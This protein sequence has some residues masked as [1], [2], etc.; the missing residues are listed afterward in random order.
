MRKNP[1]E[2]LMKVVKKYIPVDY[3]VH[4]TRGADGVDGRVVAYVDRYSHIA[5][6]YKVLRTNLYSLSPGKPIKT[7]VIT[8][9]HAWEGKTVTC[10]NTAVTLASDKEKKVL[11][12]DADLRNPSVHS[13]FGIPLDP[14]LAEILEGE[15]SVETFI[16]KPAVGD[17]YIIPAG[18]FAGDPLEVLNPAK[19]EPLIAALK[20]KFDYIVFD[21]PPVLEF[22]DACIL[23]SLC[24]AVFPVVKAA[25]TQAP[26][27][28][29]AFNMLI[30]AKAKPTACIL[31]NAYTPLDSHY[32]FYKYKRA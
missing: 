24:D 12:I 28:E 2:S 13:M 10:C 25:A 4:Q 5:E 18:T 7:I 1:I 31:T 19:V 3:I 29:E 16:K 11:L 21:T 9:S 22:T 26:A 27:L 15:E 6:Q 20:P 17:L 23:G 30:E 32:Y 14:G 8:S